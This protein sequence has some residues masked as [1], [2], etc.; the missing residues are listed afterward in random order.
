MRTETVEDPV[1]GS[2]KDT[3]DECGTEVWVA[4][5]SEAFDLHTMTFLCVPCAQEQLLEMTDDEGI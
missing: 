4:P 1:E 5:S 3:C 2:R